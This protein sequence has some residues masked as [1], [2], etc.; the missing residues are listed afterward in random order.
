MRLRF[1]RRSSSDLLLE[2]L[3]RYLAAAPVEVAAL[4][5]IDRGVRIN[6]ARLGVTARARGR[7]R[8]GTTRVGRALNQPQFADRGVGCRRGADRESAADLAGGRLLA[9]LMP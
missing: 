1:P 6:A 3:A 2:D 4:D 8:R 9:G 5:V 7:R